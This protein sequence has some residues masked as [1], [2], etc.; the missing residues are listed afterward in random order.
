MA[1]YK[2][3]QSSDYNQSVPETEFIPEAHA[4]QEK[5]F[6]PTLNQPVS[7]THAETEYGSTVTPDTIESRADKTP[8]STY[9]EQSDQLGEEDIANSQ[10]QQ[11]YQSNSDPGT[12]YSTPDVSSGVSSGSG[13]LT[14]AGTTTAAAATTTAASTTVVATSAAATITTVATA[15]VGATIIAVAFIL[16]LVVGVPSAIIFDEISVTDTTVYYSIYFEDYEEGMDLTVTLHNNFTNRSHTVESESISVLEENLKPGMDYK[17]TV[18][19]SMGAVLDEKTVRTDKDPS[20]PSGP[21]LDVKSFDYS[22]QEGRILID[23]EFEGDSSA[24]TS[25]KAV[26]YATVDD[27]KTVLSSTDLETVGG[28]QT[29]PLNITKDMKYSATF[30][31]EGTDQNGETVELYSNDLTIYGTPYY[32]APSFSLSNDTLTVICGYY[33]PYSARSDYQL[34][35]KTMNAQSTEPVI[36]HIPL[37]SGVTTV[38][39][40]SGGYSVYEF[41]AFI[42]YTEEGTTVYPSDSTYDYNSLDA[43][44]TTGTG[45]ATVPSQTS[46]QGSLTITVGDCS[47]ELT[48]VITVM[49]PSSGYTTQ[50]TTL[51]NNTTGTYTFDLLDIDNVN[52]E[53]QFHVEVFNAINPISGAYGTVVFEYASYVNNSLTSAILNPSVNGPGIEVNFEVNDPYGIWSDYRATVTTSDQSTPILCSDVQIVDNKVYFTITDFDVS[54]ADLEITCTQDGAPVTVAM[55]RT[56]DVYSGP[57]ISVNDYLYPGIYGNDYT[58]T[59]YF[60]QEFDEFGSAT[61]PKSMNAYV[62]QGDYSASSNTFTFEDLTLLQDASGYEG[63]VTFELDPNYFEPGVLMNLEIRDSNNNL[64]ARLEDATM[65]QV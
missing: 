31:I 37:N 20:E 35:V 39:N 21:S 34:V 57:K 2:R 1:S 54:T 10:I 52:V 51:A 49:D 19:G 18:Y 30:I 5:H 42:Q 46:P 59:I 61:D 16:P 28:E 55:L 48:A 4:Y 7:E 32:S 50:S 53:I 15:A 65:I 17:I 33:D 22:P 6:Q 36:S 62:F 3:R 8:R 27:K 41:M 14:A 12:Q 26:V 47:E 58:Q 60:Y 24:L 23:S 40:I 29:I 38:E 25:Y 9:T 13:G 11:D 45:R 56:I 43:L 64:I 44:I 63:T